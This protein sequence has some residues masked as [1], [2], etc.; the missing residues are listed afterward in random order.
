MPG[1]MIEQLLA[2]SRGSHRPA[3]PQAVASGNGNSTAAD[4]TTSRRTTLSK[5]TTTAPRS[6]TTSSSISTKARRV[7]SSRAALPIIVPSTPSWPTYPRFALSNKNLSYVPHWP[8]EEEAFSGSVDDFGKQ[9]WELGMQMIEFF[10]HQIHVVE[11][12][13][14]VRAPS[15]GGMRRLALVRQSGTRKAPGRACGIGRL[16]R[17]SSHPCRLEK[18]P[19]GDGN[20]WKTP[21]ARKC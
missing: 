17:L 13:D 2:A 12:D 9:H 16:G 5:P 1:S 18:S 7:Y 10:S 14:L 21:Q 19:V 3:A 6:T 4:P 11:G 15:L 8:M 20:D